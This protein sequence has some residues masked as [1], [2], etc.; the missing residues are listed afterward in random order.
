MKT[1]L[2]RNTEHDFQKQNL[3]TLKGGYDL[4]KCTKCGLKAKRVG[5]TEIVEIDGR[6][7]DAKINSCG[8]REYIDVKIRITQC[9]A[10]GQAFSNI[11][12]GSIHEVITPPDGYKNGDKGVW[13][14]GNG[15]PVKVLFNE[16]TKQ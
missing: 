2:L 4:L 8:K 10:N 12:P 11:T 3:V 14:Q 13:V 15:E 5:I 7:S 9:N 6:I 16:Y 1:L